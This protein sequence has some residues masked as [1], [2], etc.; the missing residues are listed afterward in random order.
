LTSSRLSF[1]LLILLCLAG[2]RGVPARALL[3]SDTAKTTQA[4]A[5]SPA[6][7]EG[8]SEEDLYRHSPSVTTI[9][10]WF[11]LDQEPAAKLFEWLNFTVLA[12]V[13]L[14]FAG[15][16]LPKTFR[17]NR[18]QI[19]GQLVEA[20]I[21]T[22]HAQ[23][24]LTAIEQRLATLDQ[25]IAGISKQAE[26]DS[27]EDEARIKA[28]IETERERIVAASTRD[29]AAAA[30]AAQ[31]E[32]KRFAAGLAVDRAAQRLVLTADD[33]RELVQEFSQSLSVKHGGKN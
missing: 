26:K 32:L 13:I 2:V 15:K 14:F 22:E 8:A 10:H 12:G 21:A 33:D 20:R 29:I 31:R 3:G 30:S 27:V 7:S 9:G 24:R 18:E 16:N 5:Q 11:K 25:E 1:F 6:A 4:S 28:S 19:R 23:E 17:A